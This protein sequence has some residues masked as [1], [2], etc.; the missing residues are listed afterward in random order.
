MQYENIKYDFPKMP[1]K[2]RD[3]IEREVEKQVKTEYPQFKKRKKLA[4]RTIAA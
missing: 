3:M 4:G 2:M 1:E